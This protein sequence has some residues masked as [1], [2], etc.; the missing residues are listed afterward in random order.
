MRKIATLLFLTL[1]A[2][3]GN[4]QTATNFNVSDCNGVVYDLF[5]KLDAGKVV[6]ICWVMPCG[7][8][9]GPALTSYNIVKSYQTSHPEKVFYFLVDDYADTSCSSLNAWANS[10]GIPLSSYSRR[11]SNSRIDMSDYGSHGM[12]KVVVVGGSKRTVHYN[13]NNTVVASK[14]QDA[15]NMALAEGSTGFNDDLAL[16]H[17]ISVFPSP[18]TDLVNVQVGIPLDEIISIGIFSAN[19]KLQ[20]IDS[21]EARNYYENKIVINTSRMKGGLYFIRISTVNQV[22]NSK[23]IISN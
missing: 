3:S 1:S 17:G 4:A 13:A 5:S 11:F 21:W 8:C 16:T 7:P 23:F 9:V 12:P 14:I 2:I 22:F 19:G 10:T 18:A 6:V 20:P 15:I